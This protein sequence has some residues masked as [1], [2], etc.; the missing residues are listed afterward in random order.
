MSCYFRHMKGI[1]EETGITVTQENKKAIDR[2]IHN[3]VDVK[4]K[5]CSPAWK[6]IK[7]RITAGDKDKDR[8]I[9]RLKKELK[10]L[11]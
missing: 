10:T 1:L 7:A 9:K 8:F 2:I 4:Y 11:R 3:M 6:A 5:D